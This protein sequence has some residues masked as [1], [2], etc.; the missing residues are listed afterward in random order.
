[1]WMSGLL[2]ALWT[3]CGLSPLSDPV[4]EAEADLQPDLP[5]RDLPVLQLAPDLGDLE[6]VQVAQRLRRAADGVA[7]GLVDAVGRAADDLRDPEN[8]ISM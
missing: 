8:R 7:D 2:A 6:P 4:L 5:V 3:G 1:M